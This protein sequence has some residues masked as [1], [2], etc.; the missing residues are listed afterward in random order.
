MSIESTKL[1][2]PAGPVL[3]L[4]LAF[5]VGCRGGPPELDTRSYQIE[6]LQPDQVG[7]LL[8]PYVYVERE[9]APGRISLAQGAVTVRETPDNLDKIERVLEE[10]DVASPYLRLSFQLI[11]ADGASASDPAIAEVEAQLRELFQFEGYELVGEAVVTA[12][13]HTHVEQEFAGSDDEYAVEADIGFQPPET[14]RL[15]R[16]QLITRRGSR[17]ETAVNL[18]PGQ[19]VVLGS[20]RGTDARGALILTVRADLLDREG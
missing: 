8:G 5:T 10:Y 7:S 11:R 14:I 1:R 3:A 19:T 4:A 18:R 13:N 2:V 17:F 12:R 15:A 6:H 16:V 20:S 9:G